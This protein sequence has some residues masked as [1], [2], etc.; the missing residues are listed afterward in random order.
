MKIDWLSS[1]VR[2]GFRVRAHGVAL[3]HRSTRKRNREPEKRLPT[4]FIQAAAT[5]DEHG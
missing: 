2:R 1:K 5:E 4:A 3:L